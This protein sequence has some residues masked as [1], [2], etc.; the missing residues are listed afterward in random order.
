MLLLLLLPPHHLS[1]V[2]CHPQAGCCK[3]ESRGV[4]EAQSV[5]V[6]QEGVGTSMQLQL[7]VIVTARFSIQ[8]CCASL[9]RHALWMN[10]PPVL[11]LL[12]H[13]VLTLPTKPHHNRA[14]PGQRCTGRTWHTL[15]GLM[16]AWQQAPQ[17]DPRQPQHEEG[18]EAGGRRRRKMWSGG[19]AQGWLM[20]PFYASRE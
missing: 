17:Q 4:G 13:A 18:F 19:G 6:F 12:N 5:C 16:R 2:F 20:M 3:G 1:P 15:P 8:S 14:L 10:P 9:C 11:P 7:C